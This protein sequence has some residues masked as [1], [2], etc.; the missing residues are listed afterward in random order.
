MRFSL[1]LNV[2]GVAAA[3]I[4]ARN[5]ENFLHR[6]S[7]TVTIQPTATA[8][9]EVPIQD[10]YV[11]SPPDA[12][13][14]GA[15]DEPETSLAQVPQVTQSVSI[16]DDDKKEEQKL[17]E[18]SASVSEQGDVATETSPKMVYNLACSC[19]QPAPIPT[20]TGG[21][22]ANPPPAPVP[23][24]TSQLTVVPYPTYKPPEPVTT[25]TEQ[26]PVPDPTTSS[27]YQAPESSTTVS[28]T[29]VPYPPPSSI[30]E[31]PQ[32]STTST[33]VYE[34]PS[35]TSETPLPPTTTISPPVTT[36]SW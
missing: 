15:D 32:I 5:G 10:G 18:T 13:T 1:L 36:Q 31:P 8:N 20:I 26:A 9:N 2:L 6:R 16:E 14:Y 25:T 33:E 34:P 11:A 27:T 28:D 21:Y 4:P 19:N 24:T 12:Q 17:E 22:T 29:V 23:T 30:Y 3:E 35:T 7:E